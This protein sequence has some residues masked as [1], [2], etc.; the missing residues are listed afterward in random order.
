M[1]SKVVLNN[2]YVDDLVTGANTIRE[3]CTIKKEIIQLLQEAKFEL[4]KWALNVPILQDNQPHSIHKEFILAA[5]KQCEARTLSIVWNCNMD[6]FQFSSLAHLDPLETITKQS[7]LSRISLIFDPLGLLGPVTLT[8]KMIMQDLWRFGL[9][10]D[11]SIPLELHTK[12]KRYEAE[13]PAL[14][15]IY[16]PRRI[17]PFEQY[18][19]IEVHG[20]SDASESGYGACIYLRATSH[21]GKYSVHLLCS[22]N[23][24]APLK[25]LSIPRLELC[26]ALLLAQ[27][28]NKISNCLSC[29]IDSIHLWTDSSLQTIVLAWL[30]SCNRTWTPFVANRV[31]EIQQLTAIQNW[32]HI[33]VEEQSRF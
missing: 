21:D 11:E 17:I 8:A 19:Q 32:K 3:I 22:K 16:V 18:T 31:G 5:D 12:W 6:Q 7:I 14:R 25:T 2:F 15:Q 30:Q 4:A 9:D 26:G 20:F 23:R 13:L 24:V 27:F 10:W 1:A 29:K 33:R 28:V